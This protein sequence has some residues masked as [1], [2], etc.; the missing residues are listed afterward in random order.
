MD[1]RKDKS[2]NLRLDDVT[3]IALRQL[4]SCE[5]VRLNETVSMHEIIIKSIRSAAKQP[6]QEGEK[7]QISHD[8]DRNS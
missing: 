1:K 8:S 5:I 6:Q 7:S 3:M 2:Y 4:Q